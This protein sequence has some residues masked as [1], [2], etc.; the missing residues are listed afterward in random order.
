M[1]AEAPVS[2]ADAVVVTFCPLGVVI[3]FDTGILAVIAVVAAA[4]TEAFPSIASSK[5]SLPRL[6]PRLANDG[7]KATD[8]AIFA[9]ATAVEAG[10]I[11]C[12]PVEDAEEAATGCAFPA[13]ALRSARISAKVFGTLIVV[14]AG[15]ATVRAG[16]VALGASASFVSAASF[17][18][19]SCV[20]TGTVLADGSAA[21][22]SAA[23][24]ARRLA[25]MISLIPI[26]VS[27]VI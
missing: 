24:L 26:M 22:P 2:L 14:G 5:P 11:A 18:T 6:T 21:C 10:T 17:C 8:G 1:L 15:S 7:F 23:S 19:T 16:A 12:V 13:A 27:P 3:S 4:I 9:G 25:S 20:T